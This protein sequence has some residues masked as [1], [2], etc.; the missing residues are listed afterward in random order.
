MAGTFDRGCERALPLGGCARHTLG[1]NLA[2][3]G[4]EA[5]EQFNILEIDMDN[6]VL[7]EVADL[8][9]LLETASPFLLVHD[10]SSLKWQ[11]FFRGKLFACFVKCIIVRGMRW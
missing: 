11:I 7:G 1:K 8:A 3:I 4:N 9:A 5:L 10:V 6:L 2:P